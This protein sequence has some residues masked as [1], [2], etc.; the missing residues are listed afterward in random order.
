M[1]PV[2]DPDHISERSKLEIRK[3][4]GSIIS[5]THNDERDN[6]TWSI[7]DVEALNESEFEK[8]MS[9]VLCPFQN[10]GVKLTCLRFI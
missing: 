1:H 4:S 9:E 10:T 8:M 3:L 2:C 5:P 6:A 7:S